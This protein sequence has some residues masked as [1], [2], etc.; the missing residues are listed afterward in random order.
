[1]AD[2]HPASAASPAGETPVRVNRPRRGARGEPGPAR[3]FQVAPGIPR[4]GRPVSVRRAAAPG[5]GTRRDGGRPSPA[6]GAT[7]RPRRAADGP[8]P[9]RGPTAPRPTGVSTPTTPAAARP[10]RA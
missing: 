7:F 6:A 5:S 4:P 10:W 3:R 1:V 8:R 9:G 2:L